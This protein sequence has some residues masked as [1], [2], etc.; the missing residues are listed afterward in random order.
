MH[1][2]TAYVCETF[3]TAWEFWK[4]QVPLVALEHR[5]MLDSLLCLSAMHLSRQMPK[6]WLSLEGRMA[7]VGESGS[8]SETPGSGR[9]P[10]NLRWTLPEGVDQAQLDSFAQRAEPDHLVAKR[11]SD[12]VQIAQTYFDRALDGHRTAVLN[13]DADNSQA[14]YLTSI[15]VSW[16]ALF[17]LSENSEDPTMPCNDPVQWIRLSRGTRTIVSSP[18]CFLVA[19]LPHTDK[20]V[21]PQMVGV[22][23]TRVAHAFRRLLRR[24]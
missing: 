14:V 23:W 10:E 2:W 5:Y 1:V 11:R 15:C 3:S 13:M 17:H 16:A 19:F 21:G 24:P 4:Y 22:R 6:Q 20:T 7:T 9:V 18:S 8:V 12:M